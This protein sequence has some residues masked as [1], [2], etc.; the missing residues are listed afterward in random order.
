MNPQELTLGRALQQEVPNPYAGRVGGSFGGAT[1]TRQ[2]LLRPYPYYSSI[3][4]TAPHEGSSI[5]HALLLN[6]EKRMSKGLVLLGSYTFG[7]LINEGTATFSSSQSNG[8]Q[9]SLG[10]GYRVGRF[11]R[12]LERSLDPTDSAGRFVFSGVYQF[13]F[14]SGRASGRFLNAIIGGWQINTIAVVQTGL[15]LVVRGANNFLADR[16]NSTGT[17][18]ILE[19]PSRDRW[20][21][22]TQFINPPDFTFG[23]I[24]RTLSDVRAPGTV[25]IDFS[26]IKNTKI[27]ERFNLQIRAE[28]FNFTN[29][30]NLLEPNTTFVPGTNGRNSSSTFGTIVSARDARIVQ[31]GLKLL[32]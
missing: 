24:A 32:F 5:Y 14:G 17:T 20:F 1:I 8:D 11:N 15:P 23:N 28:S 27:H 30:V 25:N 31:V 13:P 3:T 21:D 9:L 29:H 18:A 4:V 16:P 10:N 22:T 26:I 6:V 7:K 12:R 19:N 2:Q